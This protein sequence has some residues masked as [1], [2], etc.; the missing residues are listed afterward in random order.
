MTF[1][2]SESVDS[3]TAELK[4]GV[5]SEQVIASITSALAE[6]LVEDLYEY[7]PAEMD[8]AALLEEA[9]DHKR[10]PMLALGEE[11]ALVFNNSEADEILNAVEDLENYQDMLEECEG[12]DDEEEEPD[13][14]MIAADALV[15][16]ALERVHEIWSERREKL[17]AK[18]ANL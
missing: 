5:P 7:D 17:A 11:I 12:D 10:N 6:R 4:S 2:F 1:N 3:W 16:I 9:D 8:L 14:G 13:V 15:E 18:G